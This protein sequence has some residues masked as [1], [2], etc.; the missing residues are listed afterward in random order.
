[1]IK[2][3]TDKEKI[4]QYLEYKGFS[5]NSFYKKTGLSVGFLDSGNS[6]GLDKLR[7]II[8]NYHDFN[9]LWLISNEEKMIKSGVHDNSQSIQ[10]Y[11]LKTDSRQHIQQIPLYNLEASAGLVHLFSQRQH[12]EDYISI[13]NLPK[14]DGAIYVVGD[15]MYPLL[16]SGDIVMYKQVQDIINGI[17]WGEM[18]LLSFEIAGDTYTMIKWLQR[19]ELGPEY[20]KLVSENQHHQPKDILLSSIKAMAYIK[21]SIRINSMT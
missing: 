15:S 11:S 6:L 2:I 3:M 18:Y 19:S 14:C 9:P 17:F 4:I 13:P 7:V 21:A 5:K 10:D 16:K 12:V 1:M 8:D 20:I